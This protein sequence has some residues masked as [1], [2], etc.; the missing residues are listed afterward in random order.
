M[1]PV[2]AAACKG[3]RAMSTYLAGFPI[4]SE[5]FGRTGPG[6]IPVCNPVPGTRLSAER[7]LHAKVLNNDFLQK[8]AIIIHF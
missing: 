6:L 4:G 1:V 8:M 2:S 7:A 3:G 5:I